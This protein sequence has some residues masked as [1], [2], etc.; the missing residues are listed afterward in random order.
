MG[1]LG[2]HDSVPRQVVGGLKVDDGP[3]DLCAEIVVDGDPRIWPIIVQQCL[4]VR[5]AFARVASSQWRTRPG[6][7]TLQSVHIREVEIACREHRQYG[8][9]ERLQLMLGQADRQQA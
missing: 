9:D 6:A 1:G 7:K 2:R 5:H 3:Q 8:N 4:Q